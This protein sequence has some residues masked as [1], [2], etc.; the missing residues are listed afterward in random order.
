MNSTP[1]FLP[2]VRGF[3][4]SQFTQN[5]HRKKTNARPLGK[6]DRRSRVDDSERPDPP[7]DARRRIFE[8]SL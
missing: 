8:L 6:T 1:G 3:R 2:T 5:K 4:F 7:G